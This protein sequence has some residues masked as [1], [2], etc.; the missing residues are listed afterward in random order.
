MKIRRIAGC[1]FFFC[2]TLIALAFWRKDWALTHRTV[3]LGPSTRPTVYSVAESNRY[4]GAAFL[5]VAGIDAK[6]SNTDL[7]AR[8]TRAYGSAAAAVLMMERDHGRALVTTGK[9]FFPTRDLCSQSN[10]TGDCAELCRRYN[11]L[12]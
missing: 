5:P 7:R 11:E 3:A 6:T 4:C 8:L 1:V 10:L 9:L 2:G 12:H